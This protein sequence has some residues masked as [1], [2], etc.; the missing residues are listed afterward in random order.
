[1]TP[2]KRR[3]DV[4]DSL[5]VATVLTGLSYLVALLFGWVE[6]V[7]LLEAFA[8]FTSYS[9]TYLCV[10][11][12]RINYPIGAIS[13][14][15]YCILFFQQGLLASTLLN[16]YLTP[17]LLYGWFRWRSDTVGRPVRHVQL[18][19][20]PVYLG[21]TALA[22]GGALWLVTAFGGVMAPVDALILI[23]SMLAQF[24]LDNKRIETW[25]IWAIVNVAAIYVYF[26]SG[27]PL[28]GFQYVFF[29]ANTVYGF[30][31]WRK[32]MLADRIENKNLD[33]R[34]TPVDNPLDYREDGSIR[35]GDPAYAAMM[36]MMDS[37]ESMVWNQQADGT[38]KG[39][40]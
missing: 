14:A 6:G 25:V 19:W 8:V 7:N 3:N 40:K 36:E 17:A 13:T 28:A 27:L 32:T 31:Q 21:V 34:Q 33:M 16:L 5:I 9:C 10:K 22:Y 29:L 2:V 4:V 37:G 15:A 24:L 1:M 26:T 23:G 39:Q 12:R 30:Q 20:V 38:W 35:Q 11:Q 18:R